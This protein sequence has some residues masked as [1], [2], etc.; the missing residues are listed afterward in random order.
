[1]PSPFPGMDPYLES[2]DWFP[3]LH[4][5]LIIS[6]ERDAS[7]QPARVLL[8][9]VEPSLL[10]GVHP[11]AHRT[12]CRDRPIRGKASQAE[13]GRRRRGRASDGRPLGRH[14]RDHRA[15]AVQAVLPGD[16]AAAR[17]GGPDLV[18]A[19]EDPQ[20]VQQEGRPPSRAN[21][22][23]RSSRKI[24]EQRDSPGRD[25]LA[26][27]GDVHRWPSRGSRRGEGR[28]VRL[29][30]LDPSVRSAQGF[31]RLSDRHDSASPRDRASR[32]CPATRTCRSTSR[33]LSTGPTRP[34]PIGREIEYGKD[35]D[36]A[37]L[38]TRTGRVGRRPAQAA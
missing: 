36:R 21:S 1:M 38:E 17:Q 27:R 12:R 34:A 28:P 14:G 3:D 33:R 26:S 11:A 9:P 6:H 5:S 37:S 15:W 16:P 4:G 22:S 18:T 32:S 30:G 31:L 20:P 13:P 7:A 8:R 24:L 23:S 10:A 19:I 25:R 29:P 2:P 35:P